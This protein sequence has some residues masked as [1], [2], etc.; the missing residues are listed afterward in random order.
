MHEENSVI[1]QDPMN[2]ML[3]MVGFNLLN[4]VRSNWSGAQLDANER[5]Q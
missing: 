1:Y 3:T 2:K 4:Y 5:D